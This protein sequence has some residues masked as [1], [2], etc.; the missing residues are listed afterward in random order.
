M[1]LQ[2]SQSLTAN[3][4][5]TIDYASYSGNAVCLYAGDKDIDIEMEMYGGKG[6]TITQSWCGWWRWWIF[7]IRF[8]MERNVEYSHWIM[9]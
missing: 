7:D 2:H 3:G 9:G 6:P 5:L 1:R 8:T 4:D